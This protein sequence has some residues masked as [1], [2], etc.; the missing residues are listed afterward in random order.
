[1]FR[2]PVRSRRLSSAAVTLAAGGLAL[3][4]LAVAGPASSAGA[5]AACGAS[6]VATIAAA[7]ATVTT[8]IY[9]NELTGAEVTFDLARITGAADLISAVASGNR[10]ATLKAVSRIVFHPHWHIV[11]L[12]ALDP[13]GHMLADVGGPYV[14]APLSGVLQSAGRRVGSFVMSVQDD[15]G[16]TKLENRFVG[17]PIG[18]YVGGRLVA[19]RGGSLPATPPRSS[20]L[21]LGGVHYS[22][23]NETY[24]AFPTGALTALLL[25][26]PPAAS[27]A[28]ERCAT[29]RAG[30]FRRVA[31][32]LARLARSLTQ[33]YYGYA[34]TVHDYTGAQVFVRDG[35][36]QLA[37][38][39]G[40][41]PAALPTSG[42]VRYQGKTWLVSSF[43]PR[44]PTR[45]YLL[46]SPA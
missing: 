20:G 14:I 24:N 46:V 31:A 17:D 1:M 30:E 18:I 22:A 21:I 45:V 44:P 4:S 28:Q 38:S 13:A 19:E 25:V 26:A 32:R 43:Q 9:R 5:G 8:D 37:S 36:K 39:S 16:V 2:S 12:R 42:T 7:D 29:V 3:A 40:P 11:R 27:V 10:A 33:H 23:V 34:G 6:T 15:V 35:T 41:G